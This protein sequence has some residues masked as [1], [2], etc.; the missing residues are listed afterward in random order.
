MYASLSSG[1]KRYDGPDMGTFVGAANDEAPCAL[2]STAR[3]DGVPEAIG[4]LIALALNR[5]ISL[6]RTFS[7]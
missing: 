4:R 3:A 5:W 6:P 7:E 1:P 2:C